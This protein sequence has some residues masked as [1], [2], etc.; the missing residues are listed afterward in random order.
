[1]QTDPFLT[2]GSVNYRTANSLASKLL[3]LSAE[4]VVLIVTAIIIDATRRNPALR[5]R[6]PPA[7]PVRCSPGSS[8]GFF[9]LLQRKSNQAWPALMGA[10]PSHH[11]LQARRRA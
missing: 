2:S 8:P 7:A 11:V 3:L 6:N 1:M 10:R 5:S 9:L 4:L